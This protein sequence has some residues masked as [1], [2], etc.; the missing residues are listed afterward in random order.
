MPHQKYK[1]VTQKILVPHHLHICDICFGNISGWFLAEYIDENKCM[2]T[3]LN[4]Q[5]HVKN[6]KIKIEK[7]AKW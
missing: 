2:L 5:T 6:F 3:D 7:R 1:I 4:K